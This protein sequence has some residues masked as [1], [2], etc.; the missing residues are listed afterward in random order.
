MSESPVTPSGTTGDAASDPV[1]EINLRI[2]RG[3]VTVAQAVETGT[4]TVAQVQ[5]WQSRYLLSR[6]GSKP[7]ESVTEQVWNLATRGRLKLVA[8]PLFLVFIAIPA[9][10]SLHESA[11]RLWSS[12]MA[13]LRARSSEMTPDELDVCSE[14]VARVAPYET[15]EDARKEADSLLST[16]KADG[17]WSWVDDIHIARDTE[18]LGQF[19]LLVDMFAAESNEL[20]VNR[21]IKRLRES[22]PN[23]LGNRLQG[24]R[25]FYYR[26]SAFEGL[27]G[28]LSPRATPCY[29][30]EAS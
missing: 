4:V 15:R 24:A 16:M 28:R 5:E 6:S 12:A 26:Q 25:A 9:V 2:L 23:G 10:A 17:E 29:Y 27:Y 11:S 22:H 13:A 20:D 18:A 1:R 7:W 8:V 19:L 30:H 21:E 14:W 3:E